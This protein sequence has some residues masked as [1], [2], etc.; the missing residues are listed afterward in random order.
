MRYHNKIFAKQ[1]KE[2]ATRDR[3]YKKGKK[4]EANKMPI[5][6]KKQEEPQITVGDIADIKKKEALSQ[7]L[8]NSL[9]EFLN[10]VEI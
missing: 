1:I 4:G 3:Y 5:Q 8:I 2:T 7:R 9:N 6:K 10:R